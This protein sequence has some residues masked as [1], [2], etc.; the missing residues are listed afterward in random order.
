MGKLVMTLPSSQDLMIVLLWQAKKIRTSSK[1]ART[2]TQI[3]TRRHGVPTSSVGWTHA[4]AT[5][6]TSAH[7]HGL[8][9]SSILTSNA[10]QRTSIRPMHVQPRQSWIVKQLKHANG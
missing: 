9:A 1:K 2:T 3:R 8:K 4:R 10:A 6:Q 7:H 5:E